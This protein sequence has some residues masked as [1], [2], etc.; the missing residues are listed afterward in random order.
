MS[1]SAPA[2]LHRIP[3]DLEAQ[4]TQLLAEIEG[5]YARDLKAPDLS[6]SYQTA[7]EA[8]TKAIWGTKEMPKERLEQLVSAQNLALKVAL[9]KIS[10]VLDS[11]EGEDLENM[12]DWIKRNILKSKHQKP[13]LMTYNATHFASTV[14]FEWPDGVMM[15]T[16]SN[17][18]W[19]APRNLPEP[20][21]KVL[22]AAYEF[23][24]LSALS[25]RPMD[26]VTEESL[27]LLQAL[28]EDALP[29]LEEEGPI[30]PSRYYRA[31]AMIVYDSGR[32]RILL[33]EHRI[34]GDT[35]VKEKFLTDWKNSHPLDPETVAQM[36][37][38]LGAL[39][40][41]DT[42]TVKWGE[43]R[44]KGAYAME[45]NGHLT[46][47]FDIAPAARKKIPALEEE[48]GVDRVK[49]IAEEFEGRVGTALDKGH[50]IPVRSVAEANAALGHVVK[51]S[52]AQ[53]AE[54]R[55]NVESARSEADARVRTA[56][57]ET[58]ASRLY[59][60]ELSGLLTES[61]AKVDRLNAANAVLEGSKTSLEQENGRLKEELRE[62]KAE[63]ERVKKTVTAALGKLEEDLAQ[64]TGV[65]K[66]GTREGLHQAF[67]K[68][69]KGLF[70][71]KQ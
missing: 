62:A 6:W 19:Q 35:F 29:N 38:I 33:G 59:A 30:T 3:E 39:K 10:Q 64:H 48:A 13:S 25:V 15:Q 68:L 46:G 20:Y 44:W 54:A 2:T 65:F 9:R 60:A 57:A 31:A 14:E 22:V 71:S 28:K 16:G 41:N 66:G 8:W 42:E 56:E 61:N 27:V 23:S 53:V 36:A 63:A 24:I 43:S 4:K 47:T 58:A 49:G 32:S 69:L 1:T 12:L 67:Q 40:V 5:K 18:N 11:L 17:Y 37:I 51:K 34:H 45:N 52:G 70:G 50:P 21:R 55:G 7:Q 26:Q